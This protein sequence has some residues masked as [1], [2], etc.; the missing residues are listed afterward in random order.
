VIR[1]EEGEVFGGLQRAL[2]A[3]K[4]QAIDLG[5]NM[6]VGLEVEIDPFR[7]RILVCGTAAIMLRNAH[8][9]AA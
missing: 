5:A 6:V 7:R 9:A 4:R 3:L 1:Y 8:E 2:G